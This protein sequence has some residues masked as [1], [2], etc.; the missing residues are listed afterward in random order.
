[1]TNKQRADKELVMAY[2]AAVEGK[3]RYCTVIKFGTKYVT[4]THPNTKDKDEKI[5]YGEFLVVYYYELE[6]ITL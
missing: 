5:T 6:K 4:V 2:S 3:F 1:M